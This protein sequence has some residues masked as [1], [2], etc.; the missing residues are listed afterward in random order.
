MFGSDFTS[1]DALPHCERRLLLRSSCCFTRLEL[2]S[3]GET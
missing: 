1:S 2:L 3:I